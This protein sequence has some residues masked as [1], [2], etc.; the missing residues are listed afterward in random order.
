MSLTKNLTQVIQRRQFMSNNSE[1]V[2][3]MMQVEELEYKNFLFELGCEFI[4]IRTNEWPVYEDISRWPR[5]WKWFR[6]EYA[7]LEHEY[8]QDVQ[9]IHHATGRAS[10][11]NYFKHMR[12]ILRCNNVDN[13]FLHLVKNANKYNQ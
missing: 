9:I 4:E 13:G 7:M 11:L 8:I 5:Y 6:N 2:M 3:E 1:Y 12:S 10:K